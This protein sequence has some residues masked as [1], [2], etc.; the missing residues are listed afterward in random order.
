MLNNMD[1]NAKDS[2]Y[3]QFDNCNSSSLAMENGA[4]KDNQEVF[5]DAAA[6]RGVPAQFGHGELS[7]STKSCMHEHLKMTRI[8]LKDFKSKLLCPNSALRNAASIAHD[9]KVLL[10]FFF[11]DHLIQQKEP[12]QP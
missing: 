11:P 7:L 6:E 1:L 8:S 12:P 4:R 9:D 3:P 5:V 2:F 10:L